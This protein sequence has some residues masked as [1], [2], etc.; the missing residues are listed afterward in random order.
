M[1]KGCRGR[2]PLEE[3]AVH[4]VKVYPGVFRAAKRGLRTLEVVDVQEGESYQIGDELLYREWDAAESGW[5]GETCSATVTMV[6]RFPLDGLERGQIRLS[7]LLVRRP[8]HVPGD[9]AEERR[10]RDA[11][12]TEDL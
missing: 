4:E 9:L 11:Q 7:V 1:H 12:G 8:I 6:G 2:H 3:V 5:T 10:R